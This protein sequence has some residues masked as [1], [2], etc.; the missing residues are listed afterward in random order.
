MWTAAKHLG[1]A[2]RQLG[3]KNPIL[4]TGLPWA[5][6]MVKQIPASLV[7]YDCMDDFPLFFQGRR[8]RAFQAL[9]SELLRISDLVITSSEEL[10]ARCGKVNA[11]VHLVRNGVAVDR[12]SG[13][14]VAPPSDLQNIRSPILGYIG[15]IG[16][17]IDL[18]LMEAL[19]ARYPEAS[20]VIVGPVAVS[21]GALSNLSNVHFLGVKPFAEVPRY[22]REF[23]VCLIP[24]RF[25][26]LTTAVNPIKLYEYCAAGKPTVSVAI[27][28]LEPF[29]NVCYLAR[30]HD[31]FLDAVGAALAESKVPHVAA[32]LA[33]SRRRMAEQNTWEVR[34]REVEAILLEN[35]ERKKTLSARN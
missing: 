26:D 35:L 23:D 14:G 29:R 1:R 17:W 10:Y 9:T 19:A 28:E 25:N 2:I 18:E 21:V 12:Y 22:I 24:F 5:V 6:S 15:H 7:C 11:N 30:S 4:W 34:G 20:L 16:H 31:E 32:D 8:R 3:F 33:A 13:D 27:P